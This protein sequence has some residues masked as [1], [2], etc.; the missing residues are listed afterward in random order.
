MNSLA[1]ETRSACLSIPAGARDFAKVSAPPPTHERK[2]HVR[3]LSAHG[4]E[5]T[6]EEAERDRQRQQAELAAANAR[7]AVAQE[8]ATAASRV[9]KLTILAALAIVVGVGIAAIVALLQR[10]EA[11]HQQDRAEL[12]AKTAIAA[13]QTAVQNESRALAAL[14]DAAA[15]VHGL[16][17]GFQS[18]AARRGLYAGGNRIRTIGPALEVFSALA[19]THRPPMPRVELDPGYVDKSGRDDRVCRLAAGGGGPPTNDQAKKSGAVT[20]RDTV[21]VRCLQE[22]GSTVLAFAGSADAAAFSVFPPR[23]LS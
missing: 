7:A 12:A 8:R 15:R 13:R 11:M 1:N 10:N 22:K 4:R 21:V 3:R 23:P 18:Q 20:P 6:A 16:N 19:I 17:P 5:G 9:R 14:A 2:N